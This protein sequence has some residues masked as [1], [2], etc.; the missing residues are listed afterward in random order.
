MTI[1]PLFDTNF[2]FWRGD[3]ESMISGRLGVGLKLLGVA[4]RDLLAR[5]HAGL[6]AVRVADD[7]A[8]SLLQAAE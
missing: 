6:S 3:V 4:E 8:A 2:L 5:Y 1:Y 7:L